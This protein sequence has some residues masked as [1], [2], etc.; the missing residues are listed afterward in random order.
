MSIVFETK[1]DIAKMADE[2]ESCKSVLQLETYYKKNL[3]NKKTDHI[4]KLLLRDMFRERYKLLNSEKSKWVSGTRKTINY[5]GD[6]T[7]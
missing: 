2:L 3:A 5:A 1:Q 4:S 6:G 7:Q